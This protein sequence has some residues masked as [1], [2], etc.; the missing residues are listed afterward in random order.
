[1]PGTMDTWP[2]SRRKGA[3]W[4]CLGI[5]ERLGDGRSWQATDR[6][7]TLE[8]VAGEDWTGSILQQ[9]LPVDRTW[10]WWTRSDLYRQTNLPTTKAKSRVESQ[11]LAEVVAHKF[12]LRGMTAAFFPPAKTEERRA[13]LYWAGADTEPVPDH[14]RTA[15]STSVVWDVDQIAGW[16]ADRDRWSNPD[17]LPT[18]VV[19]R[20]VTMFDGQIWCAVPPDEVDEAMRG[21]THLATQWGLR[22]ISGPLAYAW[23][24]VR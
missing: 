11:T 21:L 6:W 16:C 2:I 13:L 5:P 15:R 14:I 8:E 12:H 4:T 17:A 24:A 19:G 10:M 18:E 3:T 1:M 22:I 23:P 9:L 7:P 20:A